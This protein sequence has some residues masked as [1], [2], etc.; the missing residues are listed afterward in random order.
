M[1]EKGKLGKRKTD[2]GEHAPRLGVVRRKSL[3]GPLPPA[4]V[5]REDEVSM[6]VGGHVVRFPFRPY[7]SQLV[8]MDR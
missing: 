3:S 7:P 1:M 4:G 2:G 8:M 5:A 6:H